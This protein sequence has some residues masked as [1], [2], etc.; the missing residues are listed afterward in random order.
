MT[1]FTR[2]TRAN[3]GSTNKSKLRLA[4]SK[5]NKIVPPFLPLHLSYHLTLYLC[6]ETGRFNIIEK[7]VSKYLASDEVFDIIM[8]KLADSVDVEVDTPQGAY[9]GRCPG[10]LPK[11]QV[12]SLKTK[13]NQVKSDVGKEWRI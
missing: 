2:V 4:L 10:C 5:V 3:G 13:L 11:F 8:T 9:S 1:Q 6:L 7:V 12:E